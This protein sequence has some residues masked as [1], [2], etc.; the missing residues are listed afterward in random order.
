MTVG[1]MP[2][3]GIL[4]ALGSAAVLSLGN[5]W[6]SRGVNIVAERAS[7]AGSF[8]QL[9]KTPIWL[10][11]AGLLG[12]AIVL[13]MASLAFAPLVLVQPIGVVALVF[14]ALFTARATGK[15]PSRAV[16]NAIAISLLGVTAY[17]IIA[18][19]VS[20]QSPIGDDQLIEML[21][22]LLGVLVASAIVLWIGKSG[23]QAPVLYVV[24]GGIYSGF[25]A[26]LGKT[27][28]LRVEQMFKG[29]HFTFGAEGWLTVLCIVG[30]GV[31]SALSIYFVQYSHTCNS[32]EVVIAGLTVVDPAIAVI[33]GI[34]VLQETAGA[35]IWST[36][37]FIVAG[38]VAFTGVLKLAKAD[39]DEGATPEDIAL[40]KE[41]SH[42]AEL[43]NKQ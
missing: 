23:K 38:A 19:L 1:S 36:F 8:L 41:R 42:S 37:G 21:L 18:A 28:I 33:L 20:K 26:T 11:G 31:A 25:V 12:V 15:R 16:V 6:Q 27:V 22:I 17:V 29:G 9:L 14:T 34:T 40:Q 4:L 39:T 5:I 43:P 7:G 2:L 30:I 32:P 10:G 35:P 13:Q 3:L 24:L